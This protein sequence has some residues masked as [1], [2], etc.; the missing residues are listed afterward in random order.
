MLEETT[1]PTQQQLN[2]SSSGLN[3]SSNGL[4]KSTSGLRNSR[5]GGNLQVLVHD[6]TPTLNENE[7][8][9]Q[10]KSTKGKYNITCYERKG[11]LCGAVN[12]PVLITYHDLG[13]NHV[14]CFNSFFDQP[15]VRCILPYLH[16]IHIEAPGHEYNAQT[17]DS[18][19]YPTMQ[20]M[21]EDVLDVIEYFKVKQFIGMGAGAGGGVLTQFTVDHPRYVLGLILIGS[22]IK[23]FSW[24]ETVKQWVGF[25][26]IP[27]HKNPN[28]VKNYLLNHYY[29][30]NMEE[31]NPDLREHLKRD[32]EMI[33]PENM[34]HYV[35]S[36]LKRKDISQSLIKSL[37]CK[38]LV[39]V[40]KDSSVSDDVIEVFSHFNPRYSTMLQIP[41]CGILVSAEKPTMMVEPFKLFMQG[42]G[43][44][45]NYYASIGDSQEILPPSTINN[46]QE[47]NLPQQI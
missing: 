37:S 1:S 32:M 33:N 43:Y 44:L 17:I 10:I 16:I 3:K 39:I 13:L 35:G 18:D 29:S 25:N 38:V 47:M 6:Y 21:A 40:G 45:L 27:S 14:S 30:E 9:H 41:D 8:A 5:S 28:S 34:C 23:S 24:L 42:L 20:E 36:F 4:N 15:K 12:S 46:S 31:T 2:K 7:T 11:H 22:D 26:S 19:D